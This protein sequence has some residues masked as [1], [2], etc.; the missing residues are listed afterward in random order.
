LQEIVPGIGGLP[1]AGGQ[2]DERGLA[3]GSDAPGRQHRLGR[4]AGVHPEEGGVQEQVIQH[5]LVQPAPGPGLVLVLD[6]AAD[7]RHRGLGDR[8]LIAQR[9]G[10]RGLDIPDGQAAH[11]RGNHQRLQRVRLGHVRPE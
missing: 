9:L 6:L 8:R 11:E 5:H 2:A 4:G 10:Q 3:A 1:G 7:R